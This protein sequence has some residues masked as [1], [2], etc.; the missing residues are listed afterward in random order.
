M[1]LDY[2]YPSMSSLSLV[3][4]DLHLSPIHVSILISL[5][6]IALSF[7]FDEDCTVQYFLMGTFDRISG[8][9]VSLQNSVDELN[10]SNPPRK[11]YPGSLSLLCWMEQEEIT[12]YS[13]VNLK[14]LKSTWRTRLP[15]L[16][17]WD[18]WKWHSQ[19][20]YSLQCCYSGCFSPIRS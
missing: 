4:K 12:W 20:G 5:V 6:V 7:T 11:D 17:R 14:I 10:G 16:C 3:L 15:T 1:N 2:I 9:T 8:R 19:E 18:N 13:I